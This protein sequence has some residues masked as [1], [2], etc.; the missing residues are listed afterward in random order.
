MTNPL[1]QYPSFVDMPIQWGDMDAFSH[2]NNVM[3]FRYFEAARINHFNELNVLQEM[4]KTSLGPILASTSCRFK[5]PL[6]YPDNIR[7]GSRI[8]KL[9]SDRLTMQYAVVSEK[10]GR[11]VAQGEGEIVYFDYEKQTKSNIP[12]TIKANI[13]KLQPELNIE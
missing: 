4:E 11:I 8:S 13:L 12:D 6:S 5:A 10:T 1:S 9:D 7:I 2:V 3:Y